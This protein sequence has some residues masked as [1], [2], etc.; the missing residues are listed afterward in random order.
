MEVAYKYKLRRLV[1]STIDGTRKTLQVDDSKT[2]AD[3][4]VTICGK[5]G[6]PLLWLS[7]LIFYSAKCYIL[8]LL[9]VEF[10]HNKP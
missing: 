5:M 1:V 6:N 7:M 4:M 9:S 2:I 8:N 10:R 3:L